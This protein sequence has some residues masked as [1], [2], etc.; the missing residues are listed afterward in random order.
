MKLETRRRSLTR[1]ELAGPAAPKVNLL[2]PEILEIRRFRRVQYGFGATWVAAVGI[3]ILLAL[4]SLG[5]VS[6]AQQEVDDVQAQ[7]D[8]LRS[9]LTKLN[10]VRVVN[11]EVTAGEAQLR[12][13]MGG[14]VQFS[15]FLND[16]S[17]TIPKNVWLTSLTMTVSNGPATSASAGAPT[18]P[19]AASGNTNPTATPG[20]GLLTVAGSAFSHDDVARFLESLGRQKGYADP[21]FSNSA[22]STESQRPLVT[23]SS[24]AT[25]TSD[26]L[27]HRF[28]RLPAA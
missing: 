3:V 5:W 23:F 6:S 2:P 28:D 8:Q 1:T 25:I 16:L 20:I 7:Q 19:G 18:T 11:G 4:L 24:T 26:A 13:A 12:A 17:L 21:Y 9:Q 15:H 27:S 10:G 22:V 14:E